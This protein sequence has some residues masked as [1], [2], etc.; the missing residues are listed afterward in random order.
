LDSDSTEA[1][2]DSN[3]K[4]ERAKERKRDREKKENKKK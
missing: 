4:K 2:S 3:D 1:V